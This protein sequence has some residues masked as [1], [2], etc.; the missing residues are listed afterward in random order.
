MTET[1]LTSVPSADLAAALDRVRAYR[2]QL[3][4]ADEQADHGSLDR[5]RDLETLYQAMRWVDELPAPKHAVWRGRPV[6]PRSRNRFAT[7]V[8]QQTGLSPSQTRFLH[9]ASEIELLLDS[10]TKSPSGA[11]TLRPLLRLKRAGYGSRIGEVY[12]AAVQLADGRTPTSAETSRAVRDALAQYT[13]AQ[14]RS[15][16]QAEKARDYQRRC[17]T[18]FAD[19]LKA[20][21]ALAAETVR[22]LDNAYRTC[23][24][25]AD[26]EARDA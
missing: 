15:A 3:G 18:A 11:N 10:N 16:S 14:R 5:A 13:P 25:D 1:N 9:L 17:T 24:A 6:D 21:L 2:A 4:R 22:F 8:L 7:W 20:D 19:L 12:Q 26:R 23:R